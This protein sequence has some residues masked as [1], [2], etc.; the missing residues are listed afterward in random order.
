MESVLVSVVVTAIFIAINAAVGY[1]LNRS[2]KPYGV[3]KLST[4][5]V[6]FLLV[7][8]GVIASIYKLQ[9]VAE[10]KLLSTLALYLAGLTVLTNLVIGIVIVSIRQRRQKLI[11]VHK[12]STLTM[13]IAIVL[14]V[15]FLILKI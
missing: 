12:S 13:V 14:S 6:L 1:W 15:T 10:G 2:G 3:V 7:L 4:H 5:F 8:S 11:S 9:G